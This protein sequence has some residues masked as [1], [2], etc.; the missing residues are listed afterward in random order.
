MYFDS[1]NE[2]VSISDFKRHYCL[3]KPLVETVLEGMRR[4]PMLTRGTNTGCSL[5]VRLLAAMKILVGQTFKSVAL[6]A[7]MSEASVE[8]FFGAFILH[9]LEKYFELDDTS[10]PVDYF[11]DE[12]FPGCVGFIDCTTSIWC[13]C[14]VQLHGQYTNPKDSKRPVVKFQAVANRDYVSS[15]LWEH[16]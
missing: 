5:E 4:N 1:G 12:G 9:I 11:Q 14:P 2:S 15:L 3:D 10:A 8:F 6:E 16:Q 13:T 7:Q